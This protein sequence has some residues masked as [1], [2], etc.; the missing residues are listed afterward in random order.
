MPISDKPEIGGR[1]CRPPRCP[2]FRLRPSPFALRRTSRD[3]RLRRAPQDEAR[4]SV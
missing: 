1:L 3:A 4:D 2:S